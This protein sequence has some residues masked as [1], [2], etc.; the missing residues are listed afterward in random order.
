MAQKADM[1][2]V[3]EQ[4]LAIFEELLDDELRTFLWHLY[5]SNLEGFDNIP[6][7]RAVGLDRVGTVDLVVQTY[8]CDNAVT[9]TVKLLEKM[10]LKLWADKLK[11]AYSHGKE[12]S[13][14]ICLQKVLVSEICLL[15]LCLY[16]VKATR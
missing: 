10:R 2:H 14:W 4:L 6:K 15:I 1:S 9:V 16:Q 7:S 8:S 13:W 12:M 5:S 11:E 3:K